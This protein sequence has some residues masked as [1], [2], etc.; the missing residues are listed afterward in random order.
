LGLLCKSSKQYKN[1]SDLKKIRDHSSLKILKVG[2]YWSL[3]IGEKTRALGIEVDES[4]LL[5]CWL[6]SF[7]DYNSFLE[8]IN[9]DGKRLRIFSENTEYKMRTI[10]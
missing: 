8:T 4:G 7:S 1:F 10:M 9:R 6:G 5:W 2:R 3:P